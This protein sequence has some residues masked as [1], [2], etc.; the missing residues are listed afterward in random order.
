MTVTITPWAPTCMCVWG[1]YVW[2]CVCVCVCIYIY[3][4]KSCKLVSL[5]YKRNSIVMVRG[6]IWMSF[7]LK[8]RT[9]PHACMHPHTY[10]HVCTYVHM[11]MKLFTCGRVELSADVTP[12]RNSWA[13]NNYVT[14]GH[15]Q[16]QLVGVS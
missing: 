5:H 3:K 15:W 14:R 4:Y 8:T 16:V 13:S 2:V 7:F 1:A 9:H 11:Y 6:I 12:I 10:T